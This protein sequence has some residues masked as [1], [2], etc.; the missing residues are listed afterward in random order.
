[1]KQLINVTQNDINL[2]KRGSGDSCPIA[3]ACKRVKAF[4]SAPDLHVFTTRIALDRTNFY[5]DG[6]RLPGIASAF[7]TT[8]D[9]GKAVKPFNFIVE[10][11]A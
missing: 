9:E 3:R 4:K 1:M 7:I 6:I 11:P 5:N 10:V 2:G 8:F